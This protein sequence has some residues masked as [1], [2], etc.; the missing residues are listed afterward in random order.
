MFSLLGLLMKALVV[1]NVIENIN[2]A[3]NFTIITEKPKVD[4]G[5]IKTRDKTAVQLFF[6]AKV[7]F[8]ITAKK[9]S[10]QY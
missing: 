5:Y 8:L 3:R 10:S 4:G 2:L 7:L 6:P 9:L 1:D